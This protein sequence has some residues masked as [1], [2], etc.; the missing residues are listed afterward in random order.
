MYADLPIRTDINLPTFATGCIFWGG[1]APPPTP[2]PLATAL[3]NIITKYTAQKRENDDHPAEERNIKENVVC[4]M[5]PFKDQKSADSVRRHSCV[6][7]ARPSVD[8]YNHL[9]KQ[10][11]CHRLPSS[12]NE[13]TPCQSAMCCL[14][15]Q[16]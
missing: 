9:H 12:R 7:S 5:L 8:K 6:T 10:K 14:F 15:I 11:D 2:S 16:M 1:D 13:T 4:V 3:D